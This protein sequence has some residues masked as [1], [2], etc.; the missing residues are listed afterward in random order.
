MTS[1]PCLALCLLVAGGH[2]VAQEAK[3]LE[4]LRSFLSLPG[5]VALARSD[6]GV[7][8]ATGPLKVYLATDEEPTASTEV[9][10]FIADQNRKG[11]DSSRIE[12]VPSMAEADVVLVQFEAKEKRR[13]ELDNRLTMDPSMST[14]TTGGGRTDPVY[15]SEIWGFL[16]VRDGAA[17]KVVQ[18]YKRSVRV[19][20]KRSEL[21]AAFERAL[22]KSGR[23]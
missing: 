20:E 18:R 23:S 14:R 8:P 13:L 3:D 11:S 21:R 1:T 22:K 7:L 16:L 9:Q 5:T 12:V 15:R 17:Y 6:S 19:G 4:R 2:A 10:R